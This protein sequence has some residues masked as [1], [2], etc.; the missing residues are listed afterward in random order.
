MHELIACACSLKDGTKK[1][2]ASS[3]A[4]SHR[5]EANLH[6]CVYVYIYICIERER[7]C[8]SESEREGDVFVCV[9]VS[10]PVSPKAY[11]FKELC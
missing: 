2:T 10:I 3:G 1:E 11:P 7:V 5:Q 4:F 9:C 6:I 8:E